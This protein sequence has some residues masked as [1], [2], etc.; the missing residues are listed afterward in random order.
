MWKGCLTACLDAAWVSF[1][2]RRGINMKITFIFH[3]SFAVELEESVLIFDYYGEEKLPVLPKGKQVFFL[4]SHGHPDHFQRKILALKEEYPSAEYILS[5]DIRFRPEE[6][7]DWI[8]RVKPGGELK[9]APLVVRTLRSTDLGVA[10]IVETEGKR[11]YHAGDLNW[12]HWEGEDKAWNNNM[13]ANYKKEADKLSG[14][15]FDAAF[16]PLD[17]RLGDAYYLGMQYFLKKADAAC[18]FPMH[19]WEK[20]D[21]CDRLKKD[22]YLNDISGRFYPV[23][24]PGQ[25]WEIS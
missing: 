12:W 15:F 21:I 8:H 9:T 16:V 4:N 23:E 5:R 6:K 17:P 13:A 24:Y 2:E 20:Y 1:A 3:S 19:M 22:G 18:I 7:K 25:T 11:I 14:V 10:F